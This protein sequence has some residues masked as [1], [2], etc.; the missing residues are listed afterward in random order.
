MVM[1]LPFSAAGQEISPTNLQCESK[2]NPL[3]LSETSPRLSWQDVAT[4]PS[5]RGQ[6]QTAYQ[7]QVASSPQLLAANHG[8]LWDTGQ[9]A[10]NQTSQIAYAGSTLTTDQVC[11]WHVRAWDGNGQPSVWSSPAFWSMGMLPTQSAVPTQI[12]W[13]ATGTFTNDTVLS[14]AGTVSNEVYGVDFG[15]SGA[16]TTAN[17]YKFADY[18]T[19][20]NMSI[21]G[22]GFNLYGGYLAG[23][24]TTGDTALNSILTHGLYGGV[25]NAGTLNNLT[26]GQAYK[27]I[28]LLADT[29]GGAAGGSTFTLTDGVTTSPSQQYAYANGSPSVGGYIMGTFTA[30]ATTQPL[31]VENGQN[32]QYNA[33]LLE[34]DPN[35]PPPSSP[36]NYVLTNNWTGQ[37]IGRDDAPSYSNPIDGKTYLAATHVRKDFNLSQLPTRAILYVTSLGLVEPHLNGARVGSDYFVPGWTD[38]NQRVYY[39]AYDVTSLL[40]Q[41]ANTVGA[42]LGDG[43]FRG[44]VSILGQNFYGTKTRLCAELHMF[45]ANGTSQ[46]IASDGSWTAGFGP[47]QQSDMQSGEVYNAQ[48]ELPGWDSHGFSNASWTS[49]T[50][51]AQVNPLITAAPAEPVSANQQFTP[52]AITQPQPGVYVVNFGQNIAGWARINIANQ[53]AGSKLVMQF[54][55][56][57]NPDGTV[58]RANLRSAAATDTYICKGGVETWQPH[59]TYHGFQYMQVQGLAQ[60]P[61]TSTFTG[62]AVHSTLTPAGSFQCSNS[63]INQTYSNMLWSVRDNT[64]DIPTDCDQR[65]ER[66]GWCDGTEVMRS[67]M[68]IAQGESFFSKWYQ[69]MVDGK[70]DPTTFPQMAPTPHKS[71][72]FASGWSDCGVLVPYWI[73]QT[74]GDTRVASRFYSDMQSHLQ[75]YAATAVN[76]IGQSG[77]YG[78]WLA[79]DNS[80]PGNLMS[81]AFYAGCASEMAE[82]AQALGK[83]SDAATYNQ[84]FTNICSA[85]QSNFVAGDGTVGSGSEGC[86]VLALHFNLLTPAQRTLAAAKLVAAVQAQNGHIS[87]GMVTTHWLLPTLASIGRSDLAYQ[88]LAK[89][90]YPSWGYWISLGATTMFEHWDS[91][92]ADGTPNASLVSMNSLNHANFGTC[93]EWFYSGILGIDTLQPGFKKILINP[94]VGGG[95]TSAQGY[96]NSIQGHIAS[97]WQLTNNVLTLNVTIPA[98]TTAQINVPTTNASAITESGMPAASSPGVTYVGISNGVAIYTVGSGN[99]VFSSP[100]SAS[101]SVPVVPVQDGGFESPSVSGYTYGITGS[102]WTF[103]A[104]SG[105]NGSGITGNGSAFTS[106]NQNAPEGVQVAF[107]QGNGTFSQVLNNLV[108]GTHYVLAFSAAQR[109]NTNINGQ[110]WQVKLDGT[111]IGTYAPGQTATS[112]TDYT[113]NFTATATSQTLSFVGTDTGG[114]DNTIFI[115]NLRLSYLTVVQDGGFESPTVS[116]YT[117]GITGL[118]WTFSNQS[119]A[120]GSGITGNGSA[121]TSSNQNAP[122]GVQ[123]AFLQGT[124]TFSQ[125]LNNLVPGTHY[126]LTFSA[127]QRAST[128]VNGQTW[129]VKLDGT[130]IGTYAP[131]QT[132]TSYTDYTANFTAT[133]TSQTL[134][135]VGTDTHGGDNTILI[136]NVRIPMPGAPLFS[137]GPPATATVN[138]SYYFPYQ[139]TGAPVPTFALTS[140]SLPPG[141]TLTSGG[142]LSGTPT[143]TGTY[144]GTVTAS[145]GINPN[146]TQNFSILVMTAFTQW[147]SLYFNAQ[148]LANP[149][150]SGAN[151]TPQNDGISNLLKYLYDIN[152]AVSMAASDLAALPKGG[153][154]FA[155]GTSY[156]T[157]TY[158]Q[159]VLAAGITVQ[160]QT[161]SDLQTWQSVTPDFIN[162]LGYDLTTG[163]TLIEVGVNT[164]GSTRK[165]IRLNVVGP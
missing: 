56:W 54:G 160:V 22:T 130:V 23:G 17:G 86:Y 96:Y 83:T 47:I 151:A 76:Y 1:V 138:D 44:N 48:L 156:L 137:N 106:S 68:F 107:L 67:G 104:K 123:V 46:V 82:M 115:D 8:D 89:T 45:Y 21:A 161:S 126:V 143:L 149:A 29:R 36:T 18:A 113:A 4:L 10:T 9:I 135:F 165:F 108:P 97:A 132:A 15:G 144:T 155:G 158:R 32:T 101:L 5:A 100:F 141:L 12:N 80:T 34:T 24:A 145:N 150:I 112:Y 11:Y 75:H 7:I 3:G 136:D 50:T 116:G 55:E 117:Y 13:G 119:G 124:G 72:G 110:T 58:Y 20:G 19:S 43:W 70:L 40:Q 85:F 69:D 122:E 26:V 159:N 163:D 31:T 134:S 49:V 87:T 114:G 120:N 27:V 84:L 63:L 30:T 64:F 41:G 88:M 94:Q 61:T 65:D 125:V 103:S 74:Y 109:A 102:P 121:F 152:P 157:L 92:N 77:S 127:A 35:P 153:M 39:R 133:A 90:D 99:Y 93:A 98:N 139:T 6:Y 111:V 78:D 53:L 91:L 62:V 148:Q 142:I 131:G 71:F 2:P 164:A 38:Y 79:V 33:I 42:I 105:N 37:W 147:E 66:M 73:Y 57:L 140:G 162:I 154:A 128:N 146:A 60:A 59:F 81:T 25:V 52:V 16:Q 51:G 14:L 28:V 95:L 129:Q 118:P